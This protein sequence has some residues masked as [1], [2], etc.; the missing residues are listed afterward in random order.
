VTLQEK[1]GRWALIL[2]GSSGFGLAAAQRLAANG[3]N[4]ALVHRDRKGRMSQVEV[5]FEKIRRTGVSLLTF[6]ADALAPTVQLEIVSTLARELGEARRVRVLLHAIASGNLKP[7]VAPLPASA[8]LVL[9]DEDFAQTVYAM[10]TS[11]ATW[12]RLLSARRL[13]TEDARVLGLTSEGSKLAWRNYAAVS[14]AKAALEAT[15]RAMAVEYG[16]HGI[17]CNVLQ[18]GVTDT[19]ALRLIPGH[20]EMLARAQQRNPLGRLT[21]PADVAGVISFLCSDEARFINGAVLHVDGGEA[22]A[23]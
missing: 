8:E 4:I 3:M 13:F 2:G 19:P 10:G 1:K 20:E 6:N 23:G 11:I 22:I 16:P 12:T 5:E 9:E 7:L 17:R 18:P 15:V 21:T 14:A